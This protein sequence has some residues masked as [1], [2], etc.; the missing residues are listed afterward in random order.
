MINYYFLQN[1]NYFLKNRTK[2]FIFFEIS[3]MTT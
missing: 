1:Y 2:N 3:Q